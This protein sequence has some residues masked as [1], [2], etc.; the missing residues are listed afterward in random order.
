MIEIKKLK[1]NNK[2]MKKQENKSIKEKYLKKQ[3]RK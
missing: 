2:N 1:Q 3:K